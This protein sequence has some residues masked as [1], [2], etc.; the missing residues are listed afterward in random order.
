VIR[1]RNPEGDW[2]KNRLEALSDGVF[3][4]AMTILVLDVRL[5]ELERHASSVEVFN[6][7]GSMW[8]ELMAYIIS[9][10]ILGGM[11]LGHQNAFHA[12]KK[13]DRG[14]VWLNIFYLM[15]IC[16]M[17]FS[18]SV[19]SQHLS[20]TAGL[21]TYWVNI[22]L[23]GGTMAWMWRSI[24]KKPELQSDELTDSWR[25]TIT[26]RT[27]VMP[28][29]GIGGIAGTLISPVVGLYAT[30]ILPVSYRLVGLFL[31]RKGISE[32]SDL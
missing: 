21:M 7:L 10:V 6:G 2:A 23:A 28:L 15:W 30:M 3:A 25:R 31:S 29:V 5:P 22:L 9:F 32:N 24:L 26:A 8:P 1:S 27:T 12:I 4:I 13:T 19:Y 20:T 16:L 18:T 14:V 11:W 17:P